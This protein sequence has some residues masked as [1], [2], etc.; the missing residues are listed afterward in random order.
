M[1]TW[2]FDQTPTINSQQKEEVM[3]HIVLAVTIGTLAFGA[4]LSAAYADSYYG[5]RKQ[6]NQCW[7]HQLGN[8]LGYWGPCPQAQTAQAKKK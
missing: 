5:P 3:R 4:V 8:S 1:P 2:S 6:A 7:H